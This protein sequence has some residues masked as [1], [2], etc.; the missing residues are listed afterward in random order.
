MLSAEQLQDISAVPPK[1]LLDAHLRVAEGEAVL[2]F[3]PASVHKTWLLLLAALTVSANT[4]KSIYFAGEGSL[5]AMALRVL[6]LL[7]GMNLT[8]SDVRGRFHLA[9]G[10]FDL[11]DEANHAWL[12]EQSD[13]IGPDFVVLDPMSS[14]F[15]GDENAAKDTKAFVA[16]LD[17]WRRSGPVAIALGHHARKPSEGRPE[18]VRGS[19]VLRA[20]ADQVV[21]VSRT[22]PLESE[23]RLL[24][25]KQRDGAP[26]A[27]CL[28]RFAFSDGRVDVAVKDD[29]EY[30]AEGAVLSALRAAQKPL[31]KTEIR[32]QIGRSSEDVAAAL[33]GLLKRKVIRGADARPYE[34]GRRGV[35]RYEAV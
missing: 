34:R 17:Q 24:V 14:F 9:V 29:N 3:G 4:G 12:A 32:E 1:M 28:V 30:G 35:V 25:Q 23:S 22:T 19:S 27:P 8:L 20:W 15:F 33:A 7:A 21:S 31:S 16:G 2:L 6:A 13:G 26:R 5:D 11:M 18:D 10:G